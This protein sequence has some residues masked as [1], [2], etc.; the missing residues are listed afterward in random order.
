MNCSRCGKNVPTHSKVCPNCGLDNPE[1][2]PSPSAQTYTRPTPPVTPPSPPPASVPSTP[3]PQNQSVPAP[4]KKGSLLKNLIYLAIV[5]AIIVFVAKSC[6]GNEL[7]GTWETK[8]GDNTV[9]I[10]FTDDESG[11]F[12]YD[13][14]MNQRS[15][16]FTYIIEGD[17]IELKTADTPYNFSKVIHY[18]Y[19]ISGDTLS[20]TDLEHNETVEF[21]KK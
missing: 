16:N 8:D 18:R 13:N 20:L 10:T 15:L 19:S 11:Y 7:K 14:R 17:E 21:K 2:R 4:A 1:Y 5:V 12:T 3:A 9:T 6:F